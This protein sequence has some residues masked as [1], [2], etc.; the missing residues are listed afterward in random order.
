[1]ASSQNN[2]PFR[3]S[4]SFGTTLK[5]RRAIHRSPARVSWRGSDIF[6]A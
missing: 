5:S 1:V 6:Q 2:G 3:F 4:S